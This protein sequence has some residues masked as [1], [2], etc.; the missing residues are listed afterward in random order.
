MI[1]KFKD[2]R[3]KVTCTS[4]KKTCIIKDK[5]TACLGNSGGPLFISSTVVER[6]LLIGISKQKHK[7]QASSKCNPVDTTGR[8]FTN[9][10]PYQEWIEKERLCN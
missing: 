5:A 3:V 6:Y 7:V 9:V 8:V 2:S 10:A 4:T 1:K